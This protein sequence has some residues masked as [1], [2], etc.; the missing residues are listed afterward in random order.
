MAEGNEQGEEKT[1][2]GNWYDKWYKV[3]FWIP[4][5]FLAFCVF[6][7]Y[8]FN[9]EHGDI[10]LKDVTLTGGTTI[11]I[12]DENIEIE[13]MKSS[14]VFKFDDIRA[15]EILNVRT[16]KQIGVILESKAGVDE[17]KEAVEEYIGYELNS[18]NSSIEFTGSTL[19]QGFYQQLRFAIILA[20]VFMAIVV[21]IIFRN[22]VPSAAVIFSAFAD[23]IMT[24][25][26]IN[27]M[28][29]NLSIAGVIAF[30]MLIGYS[31]DTDILLTSRVLRNSR[32]TVNERLYDSFK[33][34]ITITLTSIAAIGVAYLIIYNFSG[35]LRQIFG[36]LLVGLGFDLINTWFTNASILKWYADR[37]RL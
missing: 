14:L 1:E 5:L 13:D 33:T 28:G 30:L 15:R 27:L 36:V 24:L 17:F 18:D 6:Y 37:R 16:N 10:I 26:V 35:T 22:F 2:K 29:V 32:G 31:V 21:F 9:L 25:T 8:G 4:I 19:S 3:F 34:G 12:F 11:S 7:L 23:I 20:F